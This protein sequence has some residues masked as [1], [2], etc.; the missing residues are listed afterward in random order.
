MYFIRILLLLICF[1]HYYTAVLYSNQHTLSSSTDN[2]NVSLFEP[3]CE[4][5]TTWLDIKKVDSV[6]G[7]DGSK[8]E[9]LI[10]YSKE[11]DEYTQYMQTVSCRGFPNST[12]PCKGIDQSRWESYCS[13]VTEPKKIMYL[14]ESNTVMTKHVLAPVDCVCMV[15]RK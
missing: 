3:A 11:G 4:T 7:T 10:K 1:H 13:T 15:K 2:R 12:S 8:V 14:G 5:I 9:F 6:N